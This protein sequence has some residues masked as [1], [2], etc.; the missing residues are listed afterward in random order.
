MGYDGWVYK[1]EVEGTEIV[2]YYKLETK[3]TEK[4]AGKVW[5]A[6]VREKNRL[7]NKLAGLYRNRVEVTGLWE[8]HPERQAEAL[9]KA[10]TPE[11]ALEEVEG[12]RP[13]E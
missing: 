4:E 8:T 9:S 1:I 6:D 3:L 13:L 10:R 12:V 11:V 2:E 7:G 5:L